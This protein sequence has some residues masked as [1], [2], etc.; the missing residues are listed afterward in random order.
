MCA[1]ASISRCA[2]EKDARR[3]WAAAS[4]TSTAAAGA[5]EALPPQLEP[6]PASSGGPVSA[7]GR[8]VVRAEEDGQVGGEVEGRAVGRVSAPWVLRGKQEGK[9]KKEFEKQKCPS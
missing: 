2:A 6:P 8:F 3:A 4:A 5:D 9:K 1:A 7:R